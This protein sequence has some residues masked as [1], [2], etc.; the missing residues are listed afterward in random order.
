MFA[1][2]LLELFVASSDPSIW[3]LLERLSKKQMSS[4]R[5][6]LD[7]LDHFLVR[8]RFWVLAQAFLEE[9][10]PVDYLKRCQSLESAC[11]IRAMPTI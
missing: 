1:F 5:L 10:N 11:V 7:Q 4:W 3:P 2:D 9:R 6:L 8:M